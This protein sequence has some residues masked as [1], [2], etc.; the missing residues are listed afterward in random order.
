MGEMIESELIET[1]DSRGV[2]MLTLNRPRQCNALNATLIAALTKAL[3]R[4]D[5]AAEARLVV[6]C[7]NG[8]AFCAGGDIGWMQ[9]VAEMPLAQ[10][11]EDA[12]ALASLMVALDALSKPTVALVHGAVYGGGVGLAA[13]CDV[14]I[15]V[16]NARF[17]L[18]EVRL[19]LIPAIV[20]PFVLR[21]IGARQARRFILSAEEISAEEAFRIG[22]VHRVVAESDLLEARD[23][24]IGEL[25]AGAPEAQKDAKSLLALYAHHQLDDELMK[26]ASLRLAHRRASDEGREGMRAFLERR[27]P[28]WRASG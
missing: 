14:V 2:A 19:G 7:A 27:T 4:L 28:S 26:L 21:S 11:R 20:G 24:M 16:E 22:L 5:E 1:I 6:L 15:A 9:R 23:A 12:L 10:N 8:P 25:L 13:C 17:C 3:V 18:S